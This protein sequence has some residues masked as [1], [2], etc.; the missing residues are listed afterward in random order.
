MTSECEFSHMNLGHYGAVSTTCKTHGIT[1]P[2]GDE[3][4]PVQ[5]AKV[6]GV[7][8]GLEAAQSRARRLAET[9]G[10]NGL[11][12]VSNGASDAAASI[13]TLDPEAI[14]KEADRG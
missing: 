11:W 9:H 6:E 10:N 3:T 8:L 4:C 14:A 2:G 5:V 13:C 12:A 7:R 1:W